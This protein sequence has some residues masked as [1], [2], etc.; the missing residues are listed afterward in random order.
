MWKWH[1]DAHPTPSVELTLVSALKSTLNFG[2]TFSAAG[3]REGDHLPTQ[4]A[5]R[6]A[7]PGGRLQVQH[8]RGLFEQVAIP[9]ALVVAARQQLASRLGRARVAAHGQPVDGLEA[10]VGV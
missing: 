6:P 7:C 2:R 10:C 3:P 5:V 8:P 4:P 1:A 9:Q